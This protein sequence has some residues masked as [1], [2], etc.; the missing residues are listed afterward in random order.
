MVVRNHSAALLVIAR[1]D[2]VDKWVT[3][4]LSILC[5][6]DWEQIFLR[7]DAHKRISVFGANHGFI[8]WLFCALF[9]GTVRVNPLLVART[10]TKTF[11]HSE[12]KAVF[13]MSENLSNLTPKM[14][15][16][17]PL[18]IRNHTQPRI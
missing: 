6:I 18:L 4:G 2:L 13:A 1:E 14:S 3:H 11:D 9:E 8:E 7:C 16:G 17:L 15:V 12:A 10:F 5:R